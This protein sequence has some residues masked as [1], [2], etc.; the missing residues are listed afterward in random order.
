MHDALYYLKMLL[1]IQKTTKNA[2]CYHIFR[3]PTMLPIDRL[4]TTSYQWSIM[5][6]SQ[7]CTVSEMLQCNWRC[8][9]ISIM[10]QRSLS[11]VHYITVHVNIASVLK[12]KLADSVRQKSLIRTW[13][14]EMISAALIR[15]W[16]HSESV[17]CERPWNVAFW[18]TANS[19][20]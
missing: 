4:Y 20:D 6:M 9:N 12:I 14:F 11:T 17:S 19:Q 1:C 8:I 3:S 10:W 18:N 16:M 2:Q 13:F 7:S 5:T 15:D